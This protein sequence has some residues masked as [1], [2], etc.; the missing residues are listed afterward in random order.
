VDFRWQTDSECISKQ[1]ERMW[2]GLNWLR[3]GSILGSLANKETKLW[4]PYSTEFI[5]KLKIT[6]FRRPLCHTVGRF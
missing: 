2:T 6:I 1:G 4:V 3:T 5:G